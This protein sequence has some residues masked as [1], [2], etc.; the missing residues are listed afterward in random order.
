MN[1]KTFL[2]VACLTLALVLLLGA[3]ALLA[4]D[5]PAEKEKIYYNGNIYQT[6]RAGMPVLRKVTT[7]A[8]GFRSYDPPSETTL[9]QVM[10]PSPGT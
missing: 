5:E 8:V 6:G 10:R 4:G 9:R 3:T 1:R 7:P 2:R